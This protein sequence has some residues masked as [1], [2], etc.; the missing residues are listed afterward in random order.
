M[1]PNHSSYYEDPNTIQIKTP[2]QFPS[3]EPIQHLTLDISQTPSAM[4]LNDNQ[5][6]IKV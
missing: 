6:V 1:A 4:Q 5:T 3:T 2:V